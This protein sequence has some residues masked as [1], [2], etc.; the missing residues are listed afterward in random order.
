VY[1]AAD[2]RTVYTLVTNSKQRGVGDLFKRALMACYLLKILEMTPFFYNGGSDPHNVKLVDKV[3]MGAV[4]LRHLQN[5][6]CNAHEVTELELGP[7]SSSSGSGMNSPRDS[8]IH[9]IGAAAFS[10]LSLI[11]HS[12]DPNVVRHYYSANAV[13]RTIRTIKKGEEILD[14]YGYHYAVMSREE[15][16]RKLNNQY[17]FKCDCYACSKNWPLYPSLPTSVVPMATSTVEQKVVM[18]EFHKMTK[19]YRKAFENVLQGH[20]DDAVPILREYLSYLDNNVK[21]PIRDY[22]DCQE[23]L[24]QCWSAVAN[25]FSKS[26]TTPSR[27]RKESSTKETNAA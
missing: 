23:A 7:A 3:A 18:N 27:S 13:V 4:L 12:C 10:T 2:Y 24:K 1:D 11:N 6:P 20:Y 21:R 9:E 22:N 15:R 16:Q 17:F 26:S 5:L 14:N 19:Q 25:A 8:T